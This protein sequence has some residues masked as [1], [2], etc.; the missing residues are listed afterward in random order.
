[1]YLRVT[2][3]TVLVLYL[4]KDHSITATSCPND[5]AVNVTA[6][7]KPGWK[8][9]IQSPGFPSNY[10]PNQTCTWK[11]FFPDSMGSL[12]RSYKMMLVFDVLEIEPCTSCVC[13]WLIYSDRESNLRFSTRSCALYSKNAI[14]TLKETD[15]SRIV[16][17]SGSN[18][19]EFWLQF[20]SDPFSEFKGFKGKITVVNNLGSSS[21]LRSNNIINETSGSISSP[22]YPMVYMPSQFMTWCLVVPKGYRVKLTFKAFELENTRT[23]DNDCSND[24]VEIRDGKLGRAGELLG[25]FCGSN[26]PGEIFSLS[27]QMYVLFVSDSNTTTVYKGF[28]AHFVNGNIQVKPSFTY[29][30]L[31]M[32][33]VTVKKVL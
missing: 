13:D 1:M 21:C 4:M 25:R 11:V 12:H 2:L 22:K 17:Q 19:K 20:R 16:M 29:S 31:V 23:S 15:L 24:Y 10:Q 6:T 9:E 27:N 33:V 3:N 26:I 5:V 18:D 7:L 32:V 28:N 30:V 8:Y 14:A